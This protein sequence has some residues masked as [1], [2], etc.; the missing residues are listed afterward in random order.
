M[1]VPYIAIMVLAIQRIG[2][3]TVTIA[4]IF[5]QLLMS[6]LIDNF[7]WFHNAQILFSINRL[8]AIICLGIALFFIYQSNKKLGA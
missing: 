7:G 6:M 8:G 2:T 1:G 4:V 3:A 5:S